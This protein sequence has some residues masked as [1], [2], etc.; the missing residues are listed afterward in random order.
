MASLS[1]ELKP[2]SHPHVRSE[3]RSLV[4]G[5]SM[6]FV[7]AR[8][9]DWS[10]QYRPVQVVKG[11]RESL[12]TRAP[13]VH[14]YSPVIQHALQSSSAPSGRLSIAGYLALSPHFAASKGRADH[15]LFDQVEFNF[16]RVTFSTT[17]PENK[18]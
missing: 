2:Y 8:Y 18:P 6:H 11:E 13:P 16:D 14:R 12:R 9:L 17:T 3:P 4:P 5:V 7:A 10:S 15:L 1:L